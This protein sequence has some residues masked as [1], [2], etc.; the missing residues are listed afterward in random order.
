VSRIQ[1]RIGTEGTGMEPCPACGG[2]VGAVQVCPLCSFAW[3]DDQ[4]FNMEATHDSTRQRNRDAHQRDFP[5][6]ARAR[7][8]DGGF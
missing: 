7:R 3:H 1:A 5:E 4:P 6:D 8:L 2:I